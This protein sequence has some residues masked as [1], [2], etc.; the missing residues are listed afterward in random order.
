MSPALFY[1]LLAV[2]LIGMELWIMQLSVFWFMFI[3]LGALL[4]SLVGWLFPQMSWVSATALFLVFSVIISVALYRPLKRWQNKPGAMPGNDALGQSAQV[5][6][7]ISANKQG[8]VLWSGS[9]W[10]AELAAEEEAFAVGETAVIRKLEG[11][12]L[13]VG[14]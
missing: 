13:I 1:L 12:R 4:T 3:G 5:T 7:P 6:Q 10:P 14:R 8:K 2:A 9:E 11:I